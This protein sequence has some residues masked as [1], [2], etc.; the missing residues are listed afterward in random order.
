[1]YSKLEYNL[2]R[3]FHNDHFMTEILAQNQQYCECTCVYFQFSTFTLF[4]NLYNGNIIVCC[5]SK[6]SLF[7]S[8]DDILNSDNYYGEHRTIL[9]LIS[10]GTE[11]VR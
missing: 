4:L 5:I 1:M 9:H 2:Q 10:H 3:L 7:H 11:I 6:F 8:Y